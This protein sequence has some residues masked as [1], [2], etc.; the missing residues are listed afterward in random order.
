MFPTKVWIAINVSLSLVIFLLFL[1]LFNITIPSVGH[2]ISVFD[3]ELPLCGVEWQNQLKEIPDINRC[4]LQARQQLRCDPKIIETSLG[5]ADWVCQTGSES[6]L[7]FRLNNK[8]YLHCREQS[9]WR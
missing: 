1:N 2:A 8:A 6:A 3:Q 9:F 5:R 4:C 7:K